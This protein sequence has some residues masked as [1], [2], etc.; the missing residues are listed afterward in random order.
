[1]IETFQTVTYL[2]KTKANIAKSK[3]NVTH[4][5]PAMIP[6]LTVASSKDELAKSVKEKKKVSLLNLKRKYVLY[7]AF[8]ILF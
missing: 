7:I 1:M 2:H 8:S 6:A 5:I 4:M 3:I